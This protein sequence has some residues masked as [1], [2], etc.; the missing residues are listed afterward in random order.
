MLMGANDEYDKM[1]LIWDGDHQI[2]SEYQSYHRMSR[3]HNQSSESTNAE[4]LEDAE[5]ASNDYHNKLIERSKANG[6]TKAKLAVQSSSTPDAG[7]SQP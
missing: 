7:T 1:R 2:S 3:I 4:M 5:K 6:K